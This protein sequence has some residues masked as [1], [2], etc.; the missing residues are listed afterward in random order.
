MSHDMEE[1]RAIEVLSELRDAEWSGD[2]AEDFYATATEQGLALHTAIMRLEELERARRINRSVPYTPPELTPMPGDGLPAADRIADIAASLPEEAIAGIPTD[3]ATNHDHY[4]YGAPKRHGESATDPVA[5][6]LEE[7]DAKLSRIEQMLRERLG[8]YETDT[9][10][11]RLGDEL[12]NLQYDYSQRLKEVDQLRDALD[13]LVKACELPG[14][15]C[16]IEQALPAAR[17]ALEES[18][19]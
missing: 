11:E 12:S 17:K 3:G 7:V 6:R 19:P 16:E 8:G 13:N 10:H 5:A 4:L 2:C 14:H 18:T 1:G 9:H 15:H